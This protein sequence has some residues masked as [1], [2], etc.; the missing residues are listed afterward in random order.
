MYLFTY[1][2]PAADGMFGACH[3]LDVP[4]VWGS[5]D[6]E[7][8]KQFVGVRPQVEALSA[9][10][11]DAWLSFARTGNPAHGGLPAWPP[12]DSGRRATMIL[13]ETCEIENAPRDAERHAWQAVRAQAEGAPA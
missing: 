10:M 13:G 12:Y 1:R 5:C 11:Q 3:T 9:C 8:S 2:S 4:F 6:A 7:G